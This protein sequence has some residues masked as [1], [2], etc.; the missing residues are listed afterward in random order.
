MFRIARRFSSKTT[1]I[2]GLEK[3]PNPVPE[4]QTVYQRILERLDSV[5][6]SSYK[7]ATLELVN[8]RLQVLKD[9]QDPLEIQNRIND[10]QIEELLVMAH[11]ELKLIPEMEKYKVW[12][13]LEHPL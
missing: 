12:E 11:D 5:Q 8:K 3:H 6:D 9:T 4:L 1:G 7:Q 13:P 10:G 2:V